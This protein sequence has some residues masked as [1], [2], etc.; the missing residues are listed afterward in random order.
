MIVN[1][2]YVI[3]VFYFLFEMYLLSFNKDDHNHYYSDKCGQTF[4]FISI[5]YIIWLVIGLLSSNGILFLGVFL[6]RAF[7]HH[8]NFYRTKILSTCCAHIAFCLYR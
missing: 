6:Y 3:G 5:S 4:A 1:L 8:N 2:F 7:S